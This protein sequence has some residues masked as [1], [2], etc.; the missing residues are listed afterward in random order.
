L[1]S[2][3]DEVPVPRNSPFTITLTPEERGA[4]E[5][6]TAKYTSPYIDVVRAKI[7]LYAADQMTN[8]HIAERLDLPRQIV[9][10]WRKRFF[11]KRLEGL[12]ERPRRGRPSRFSPRCRDRDQGTR[13]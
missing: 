11:E 12:A 2:G 10:K 3:E 5:R 4:L 7:V 13:V 1:S 6:V 9:C 8:K